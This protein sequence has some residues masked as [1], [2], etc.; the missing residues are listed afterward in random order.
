MN[1][2][3]AKDAEKLKTIEALVRQLHTAVYKLYVGWP[4][5]KDRY[6]YVKTSAIRDIKNLE[7]RLS[8]LFCI[9]GGG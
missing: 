7:L 3:M 1:K 5:E 8:R 9:E 6:S 4:P 2:T